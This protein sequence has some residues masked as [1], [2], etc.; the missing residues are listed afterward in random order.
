MPECGRSTCVAPCQRPSTRGRGA[1]W[2]TPTSGTDDTEPALVDPEAWEPR[3]PALSSQAA[4]T[5]DLTI[6]G[7][8][9]DQP[10]LFP[11]DE[12]MRVD[13]QGTA[14][15]GWL[16]LSREIRL[17]AGIAQV[18]LLVRNTAT[19]RIAETCAAGPPA[20]SSGGAGSTAPTKSFG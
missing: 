14:V 4:S 12:R 10:K 3:R 16:T 20:V 13:L 19:G 15:G 6:L 5:R 11:L 2:P 7:L 17:P 1:A 18:K 8:S 9:R